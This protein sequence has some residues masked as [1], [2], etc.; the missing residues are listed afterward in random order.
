M[1][2]L[3]FVL[4][5]TFTLASYSSAIAQGL[6]SPKPDAKVRWT[7][8]IGHAMKQ[9]RETGRP[10]IVYFTADYCGY[11]RKMERDTWS[12]PKVV[13]RM[14]DGFVALKVD[15][16]K[17]PELVKRLG[18]EGLP[19]TILFNSEGERV[20]TLSGYSRSGTVIE[21]L[22]SVTAVT[23]SSTDSVTTPR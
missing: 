22:D 18:V 23:P 16:E 3:A 12:A 1:N 20:Q 2:R 9:H 7:E 11:C 4:L 8:N 10:M 17:H 15:A 6:L 14:Q 13:R 19:A 5:T 21:F